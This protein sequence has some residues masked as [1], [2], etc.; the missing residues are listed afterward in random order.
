MNDLFVSD[1]V[2]ATTDRDRQ[3]NQREEYS[4]VSTTFP[5]PKESQ[6]AGWQDAASIEA[7]RLA[8]MHA[9]SSTEKA[10]AELTGN[11]PAVTIDSGP[12]STI[13]NSGP[14]ASEVASRA[15]QK[16]ADEASSHSMNPLGDAAA[17]HQM[18]TDVKALVE[19]SARGEADRVETREN[20]ARQAQQLKRGEIP[21][22]FNSPGSH[23]ARQEFARNDAAELFPSKPVEMRRGNIIG[24]VSDADQQNRREQ[25]QSEERSLVS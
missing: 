8:N 14:S 12:V 17:K 7:R 13:I 20:A 23:H 21:S 25:Q 11:R 10:L 15:G 4:P 24:F 6:R 9:S 18:A 19:L 2:E 22:D 3:K 1:K 16:A 5:P